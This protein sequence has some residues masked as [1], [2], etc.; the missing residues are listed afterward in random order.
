M[1]RTESA[2]VPP[3]DGVL[4]ADSLAEIFEQSCDR[5]PDSIALV[6]GTDRLTYAA[7]DAR[8]NQLAHLLLERGVGEGTTVG[9][10]LDRSVELYVSLLGVL[11]AGAAYVP[12]DPTFPADRVAFVAGDAGLTDLVTTSRLRAHTA[13]VEGQVLAVDD[14]EHELARRPSTRPGVCPDPSSPAYVIYTSGTTGRPK[15]V[16]ISQGSIVNFLHVV[17]PIYAV[18]PHDRV[19]QGLSIAFDFSIEEIWP[20]WMAGATLV[21][22]PGDER[23]V[24]RGL[25]EFLDEHAIT[26]LCCVPT[27]LTTL[28]GEL[29]ALRSL[30]VS[31]EA[32]P[33][34]LVKRWSRPGRRILNAYGPT[35]TT[36]T[37]TCGELHP[38]RNVTIGTPLPTY[39]VY[40]LDERLLPVPHGESGE[41]CVGGPGVAIGYVNRPELTAERFIANPVTEDRALAP[42]LYRTGDR[43][44]FTAN[45]EIEYGGR[46]DTQVKIRGYRVELGEIEEVLREDRA[47]ENAVVTPLERDGTVQD[48]VGYVTLGPGPG[49]DEGVLRERLHASLRRRLP[50]YMIP[51][52]VEVLPAFPLLA[53]DKVDRKALPAP[54]SP[55]L[56]RGA[57]PTVAPGT[58]LERRLADAWCEA[59][60]TDRIS[61]TDD[62]FCDL[63][64]HSMTAARLV[65]LLRQQPSL[66]EVAMGDLYTHPTVRGL[67][68]LVESRTAAAPA[69][70][71]ETPLRHSTARVRR[72]GLAQLA[73]LYAWLLL[74]GLPAVLL[75]YRLCAWL[76]VPVRGVAPGRIIDRLCHLDTAWFVVLDAGWLA[77]SATVLPVLGARL[78]MAGVRPGRYPLWGVTYWRFWLCT[79]V[80]ALSPVAVLAGSPLLAPYLRLLG[81]RVGRGCHLS[82]PPALPRFV[83]IGDGTSIGYGARV[84]PYAVEHG[85]L[86]LA[87]VR[88]GAGSFLGTNSVVLP[89]ACVGE[90]ATVAEQSLIAAGQIVP[91]GEH[92]A[93][94]PAARQEGPPP[95]LADMAAHRAP[96]RWPLGVL[97]GYGVAAVLLMLAPLMVVA[98]S[99]ALVSWTIAQYGGMWGIASTAAAGPLV[100]VTTC[101]LVWAVK[102]VLLPRVRAGIHAER[103]GFGLRKWIGDA[104]MTLSLTMT[105][106]LYSTLYLV[107]FLRAL[108]ARTGRWSEVATVSFVDPD[109][110]VVG[111]RSFVAD[112]AVVAPAVFHQGRIAVAPGEVG[113]RSFVGNGALVPGNARLGDNALLGVHSLAPARPIEP[114]TTWLGS[115][116]LF[117][118]RREQSPDFPARLTFDPGRGLIAARLFIEFFRVTLPATIGGLSGLAGLYL[119]VQLARGTGPL[120]VFLLGPALLLGAGTAATLAV[121]VLKWLVIGRYRARTEALWSVWVRRTE[122]ITGLFE[123]LVVP[124]LLGFLTGTPLMPAVLRLFGARVG[125]RV[126]LHTT[127]LTEFDLV[128]VGDDAAVGEFTSLQ[129]HLFEDRVM[130]MSAVKIGAGSSVGARSVVLYGAKVGEGARLD[131]MSLVMKGESL[132]PRSRWRGIPARPC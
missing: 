76:E 65:S 21:A 15:G 121:V 91:T 74:L 80:L 49:H 8:A 60:G 5:C 131:A 67:A 13:E 38:H 40:I 59:L 46:V 89:G 87:P 16:A 34:G 35:E 101:V 78:L 127:Y 104:M 100:A 42:R 68:A 105:H 45:G 69:A 61:V 120:A 77:F 11:K 44:R 97:A 90:K 130:K 6:C 14:P 75:L 24:G 9:L 106:A 52:F 51:S 36:V 92:W 32:C 53:A 47:V 48:L 31:G 25:A 73:G 119:A 70:E 111:E 26:V 19:Y 98:P 93:G 113:A 123:N 102:R 3:P 96:A 33:A 58:P 117:L 109:M 66:R 125:R 20:A 50:S 72:C 85:R 56:G 88:F 118:P 132:P 95:V 64:G 43:G 57:R 103:G 55:P 27:L 86:R 84:H 29:P 23:R 39:R 128:E 30:L 116:A 107:P 18:G 10:L 83:E 126:W 99:T 115:P 81:A 108:G 22:G 62:F 63:G 28:D 122:L 94:S 79:K 114:E 4:R 129:T 71:E 37:A 54:V 17:A 1:T 7:L 2:P 82:S 41:I 124:A 110:L 112:I 12:L